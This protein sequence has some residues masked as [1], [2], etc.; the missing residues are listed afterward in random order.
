MTKYLSACL[1]LLLFLAIVPSAMFAATTTPTLKI[2]GNQFTYDGRVVTFQGASL[3]GLEYLPFI[4]SDRYNPGTLD[5]M[6]DG[7]NMNTVTIPMNGAFWLNVN[8]KAPFYKQHVTQIICD[9]QA[10]GFFVLISLY[11]IRPFDAGRDAGAGYP[12]P[13]RVQ[14]V[15]FWRDVAATFKDDPTI[16]FELYA[17]PHDISDQVWRDGGT[18]TSQAIDYRI[19]GTYEAIGMQEL[20]DLVRGIAPNRPILV[21][22]PNWGG[23]TGRTIAAGYGLRGVNFGYSNHLYNGGPDNPNPLNWD[24]TFGNL[25]KDV[26]VV[27]AEFGD[28]NVPAHGL[29]WLNVAM[30]YMRTY[31]S[32]MIAWAWALDGDIWGRPRLILSLDGTPSDYGKPIQ[33]FFKRNAVIR[34]STAPIP[35]PTAT[36]TLTPS[37][38]NTPVPTNTPIATTTPI[39]TGTPSTLAGSF[40]Y[41]LTGTID[42]SV[43]AKIF[44]IDGFDVPASTVATLKAQGK[45]TICYMS[46]GSWED[47]RPDAGTFPASVKGRS[48]GWP[49]EMWLDIRQRSVLIPLMTAR[50]QLCKSKGFQGIEW[51][52]VDG[53]TNSTGFPLSKADQ[54]AYNRA[55]AQMTKSLGLFVVLK[56]AQDIAPDLVNDFD[57][58]LTE[59]C[60]EYSECNASLPFVKAGKPVWNVEYSG[61]VPNICTKTP[62]GIHT[63]RKRLS[64]NAWRIACSA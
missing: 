49:G 17:E 10:R 5:A 27:M 29:A 38:T 59:Q 35:S 16:F 43:A 13:D 50:A 20:M 4:S 53:Y 64:L 52:N 7:W 46:A 56:N 12:M 19:A 33:A 54:I 21:N 48:N 61:T 60:I 24:G 30:A 40:Q 32:G 6:R 3:S 15:A 31:T 63:I 11:W 51:D 39:P 62:T 2:E 8:G 9:A 14:S 23:I 44:D 18:V 57:A 26:P 42:P 58:L 36:P 28:T 25:T 41:Q 22:G 34:A 47:W 37:P 55:L 1:A 45:T